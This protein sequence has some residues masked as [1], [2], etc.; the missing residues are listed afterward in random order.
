MVGTFSQNNGD[1]INGVWDHDIL[2][3]IELY[4]YANG[5]EYNGDWNG[6]H[7]EGNGILSN[8]YRNNDLS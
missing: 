8:N 6:E 5:D 7:K 2:K 4:R 1:N 3:K